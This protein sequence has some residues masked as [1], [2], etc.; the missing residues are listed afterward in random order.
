MPQE[1]GLKQ[2][3]SMDGLETGITGSFPIEGQAAGETLPEVPATDAA[4][5]HSKMHRDD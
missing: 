1:S 4:A 3:V 5:R 2:G